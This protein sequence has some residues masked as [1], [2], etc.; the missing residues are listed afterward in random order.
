MR[1]VLAADGSPYT[2]KA[3]A[4]LATHESLCGPDDELVVVNVQYPMPPRV[5]TMVGA[6]AVAGYHKDEAAKVLDPIGTLLAR[7]AIPHRCEW[8]T[9]EPAHQIL[10][11]AKKHKAHL[12]VM[13][14][15][16]Y[17]AVGRAL[18][19]SIAQ[20][21]LHGADVPVLLVR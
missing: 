13:G 6:A 9:G 14:T 4:F 18:L 1:I 20:R 2:K 21:V 16:G 15:H 5:K 7:K 8:T 12:I 3:I 10:Q 11:A 19:G 17:G